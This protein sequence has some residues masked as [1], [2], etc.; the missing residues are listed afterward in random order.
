MTD[1]HPDT[2]IPNDLLTSVSRWLV[3]VV[4]KLRTSD[5]SLEDDA[6]SEVLRDLLGAGITF[7]LLRGLTGGMVI[8]ELRARAVR[9]PRNTE[10]VFTGFAQ[11]WSP[12][13]PLCPSCGLP[14]VRPLQDRSGVQVLPEGTLCP[15][16]SVGNVRVTRFQGT[17]TS[18]VTGRRVALD[19]EFDDTAVSGTR[20]PLQEKALRAL[21][22]D[23]LGQFLDDQSIS[24]HVWL[25]HLITVGY[26]VFGLPD[27]PL[28]VLRSLSNDAVMQYGRGTVVAQIL[29]TKRQPTS[30]RTDVVVLVTPVGENLTEDLVYHLL[31]GLLGSQFESVLFHL[32]VSP[33]NLSSAMAPQATRARELMLLVRNRALRLQDV[34]VE[35]RV[36]QTF[37]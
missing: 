36:A 1:H 3:T 20:L 12:E 10:G 27:A 5:K 16:C 21:T 14:A 29:A 6:A 28:P 13:S 18:W 17:L 2:P 19:T 11:A 33:A 15:W 26:Q 34:Y 32:R 31:C 8:E 23:D 24:V 4:N 37:R 35:A 25:R 30:S 9:L 22:R 7:G